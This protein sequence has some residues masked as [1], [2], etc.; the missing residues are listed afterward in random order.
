[1]IA[2]ATTIVDSGDADYDAQ[3]ADTLKYGVIT[4]TASRLA[5]LYFAGRSGEEVASTAVGPYTTKYRTGPDWQ[6]LAKEL[7]REAAEALYTAERWGASVET[8]QIAGTAGPTR[9]ARAA[10]ARITLYE[11]QEYLWPAAL[12]GREFYDDDRDE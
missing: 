4:W 8:I 12:R 10:D 2:T 1:M 7:A 3:R 5:A 11:W 9:R 6:A